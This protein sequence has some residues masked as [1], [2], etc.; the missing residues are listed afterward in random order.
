MR[1]LGDPVLVVWIFTAEN[2]ISMSYAGEISSEFVD[3]SYI[4]ETGLNVTLSRCQLSSRKFSLKVSEIFPPPWMEYSLGDSPFWFD[5]NCNFNRNEVWVSK[6]IDES[7]ISVPVLF[8]NPGTAWPVFASITVQFRWAPSG[9]S[10]SKKIGGYAPLEMT[11]S[12]E[13]QPN[14][15]VVRFAPLVPGIITSSKNQ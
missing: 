6:S 14:E 7:P 13:G 12:E 1:W 15:R 11:S 8:S 9:I 10:A 2:G 3:P 5:I 4:E